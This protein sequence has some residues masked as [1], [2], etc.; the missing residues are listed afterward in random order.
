M[1][2]TKLTMRLGFNYSDHKKEIMMWYD[3]S[4]NYHY[5]GNHITVH[6]CIMSTCYTSWICTIP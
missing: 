3:K 5:N 1:T 2:M 6:Q 4:G